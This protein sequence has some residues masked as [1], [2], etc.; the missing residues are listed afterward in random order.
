MAFLDLEKY[1]RKTKSNYLR[2]LD[3]IA[4]FDKEHKEGVLED[5][6]FERFKK[7]LDTLKDTYDMVCYFFMLWAKP[8]EEE[9]V[10]IDQFDSQKES[11]STD[12]F[13]YL[14]LRDPDEL[15]KEQEELINDIKE[16]LESKKK[17]AK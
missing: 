8:S 12:T 10:L 5:K 9:K 16:Y 6:Y 1:Y 3:L 2:V 11:G 7:N 15:L 13:D 4:Q 14:S 17:D